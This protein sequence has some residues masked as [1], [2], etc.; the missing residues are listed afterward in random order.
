M[1]IRAAACK[2]GGD[3]MAEFM[4]FRRWVIADVDKEADV[5]ALV[6]AVIAPA[7]QQLPGCLKIGLLHIAGTNAYLATQHWRSRAVYEAAV[8]A[9]EYAKWRE[10]YEPAL[11]HWHTLMTFVEEWETEDVLDTASDLLLV[12]LGENSK[13]VRQYKH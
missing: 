6:R 10:A 8:T 7:Y 13:T 11:A 9:P 5:V 2:Q 1:V 4:T 12:Q 3:I